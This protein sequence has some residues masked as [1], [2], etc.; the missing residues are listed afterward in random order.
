M[1]SSLVEKPLLENIISEKLKPFVKKIDSEAYYARDYLLQLGKEGFFNSEGRS[2][3]EYLLKEMQ[4][5]EE[6][7]KV[8]MTTAFCLW[9]HLAGLTYVRKTKNYELKNKLLPL[10]ENGQTLAATGLSNPMKYYA[11]LEKLHL[12]AEETDGGYILS[13]VLP[14]VSNLADSH[15]FGTIA[16][17]NENRRVMF[18][19]PCNIKGLKR[20]EKAG[21]LGVNGSATYSC[22][23][24]QVFI[25]HNLVLAEDADEFVEEIRPTF[26]LYQIPLGI[27][28][29]KASLES[30][31]KVKSRQNGCNQF[32]QKQ[33]D[34]IDEAIQQI[35]EKIGE[36]FSVESVNWKEIAKIRLETAYL[37]LEAT[38]TSMLHNG[39]A[40]YLQ[41]CD[42]SR[43]LREAYFYANLTPTIKHLEKV[44]SF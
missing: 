32:L 4:L 35:E 38:Q 23:F 40:G 27:G 1:K 17:V 43:R 31:H 37:T 20:K 13:G 6:T 8:C 10:M 22:Q 15:W 24:D 39:S 42:P 30:I 16:S 26:I 41:Y 11:G 5:V 33:A 12:R 34:D 21:F 3:A 2:E 29:T 9:C 7:A 36:L 25:P 28:V 14:A 18:L 19:V 44:L